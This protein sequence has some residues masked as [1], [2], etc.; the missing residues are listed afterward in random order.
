VRP[1]EYDGTWY[2]VAPYG[3]V[4]WVRN[5]R[6]SGRAVLTR[7]GQNQ[8][9][10]VTEV[11]PTASAEVLRAYARAVPVTRPYFDT[12]PNGSLEGFAAEATAHP[13]FRI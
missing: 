7:R 6:A 12:D 5:I 4:G 13:V 2:L 10:A 11:P 1:I 3:P 9:I 8:D